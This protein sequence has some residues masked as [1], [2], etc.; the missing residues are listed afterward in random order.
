MEVPLHARRRTRT[1]RE[2][3]QKLKVNHPAISKLE[4]R[5]DVYISSLHSYIE[6]V[7]DKLKIVAAFPEGE[8]EITNFSDAGKD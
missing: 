8:V 4:Q 6:A 3:G 5:I 7:E 2:L 1:L